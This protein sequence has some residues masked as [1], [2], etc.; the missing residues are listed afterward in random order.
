VA[1]TVADRFLQR[2]N[3]QN[4]AFQ[5]GDHRYGLSISKGWNE[6]E[7]TSRQATGATI[8]PRQGDAIAQ[9]TG[10]SVMCQESTLKGEP[11]SSNR[12]VILTTSTPAGHS[13]SDIASFLSAYEVSPKCIDSVEALLIRACA[14]ELANNRME[15]LR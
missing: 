6:H 4:P 8:A 9:T 1:R 11:T 5:L 3:Q 10:E 2:L 14:N 12:S 15:K 13:V 7:E